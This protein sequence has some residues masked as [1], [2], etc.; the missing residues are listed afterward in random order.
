M[1]G[2]AEGRVRAS[3]FGVKSGAGTGDA[4][5]IARRLLDRAWAELD[6]RLLMLLLDWSKAF[7]RIDPASM[8]TALL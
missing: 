2:G 4:L 1:R 6:G 3:Q 8:T 5:F 7:D